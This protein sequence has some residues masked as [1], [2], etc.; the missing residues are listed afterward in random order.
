MSNKVTTGWSS[1]VSSNL[2]RF[3]RLLLL[4]LP[5]LTGCVAA[6]YQPVATPATITIMPA[7]TATRPT[8][9]S[10]WPATRSIAP[11]ATSAPSKTPVP[12]TSFSGRPTYMPFVE[13]FSFLT[14]TPTATAYAGQILL[15]H[16]VQQRPIMAYR[17]GN[18]PTR[19]VFVG[20]IHGG[21][22]WNTILLAYAAVDYLQANPEVVPA[23]VTVYII[24]SANPD[25]QYLA[26]GV[27]GR[28]N[29]ADVAGDTFAGRF[30]ANGVDLNRNW[31]CNWTPEALWRNEPISGG[32]APFSEPE[33]RLLRDFL[34]QQQPAAVIFWHSAANGV[35]AAGCPNLYRPSRQLAEIYG[36]AAGY[37]VYD[38]FT[39][40][41][42]TG[43]ATDWLATQGI[44]A[45]TV[46]LISHQAIDWSKNR[47]GLT[48]VIN[49]YWR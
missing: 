11:T 10:L 4:L 28:F 34:L 30:N 43:D 2:R 26:T 17:F 45:I 23:A 13:D 25:G 36:R 8:P 38:F 40:Y 47:A 20:G 15:G 22:E 24:T 14:V 18:G 33:N 39:S 46:E 5:L 3:H 1:V 32:P 27:E 6:V 19:L 42:V 31:D 48:A 41:A 21:Y 16:S 49:H 37:P 29:A 44:P 12:T 35:F 7:V 9:E